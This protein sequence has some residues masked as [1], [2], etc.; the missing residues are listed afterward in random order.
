MR[1]YVR[2]CVRVSARVHAY[3]CVSYPGDI[4]DLDGSKLPRL[5]MA[6]LVKGGKH[7]DSQRHSET[8]RTEE[9]PF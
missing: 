6:T 2:V 5:N 3:M 1:G 4:H 8:N 9:C 7:R